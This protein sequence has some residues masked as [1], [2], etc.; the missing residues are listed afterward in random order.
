M[1]RFSMF[2]YKFLGALIFAVLIP[3]SKITAQGNCLLFEANSGERKACEL[4]YKASK[5]RQGSKASQLLFD[6]AIKVGSKFAYA[7]YQKSVPFFKRGMFAEGK[8]LIDKAISLEP[9]NYLFYRA[10]YYFYNRSYKLCR[11][12]LEELYSNHGANYVTTPGGELEMRILLGISYGMEGKY[13]EGINWMLN[14]M[15]KYKALPHLKGFYDH[16]CLGRLY[17][18]N[19]QT[20]LAQAEFEKQLLINDQF[21]DTFYYLGLIKEKQKEIEKATTYYQMALDK[22]NGKNGGFSSSIFADYN[23]TKDMVEMKITEVQ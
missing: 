15:E 12:D 16:Y 8:M 18:E 22:M 19:N 17:Y 20:D 14:L 23:V 3:N 13:N 21:A 6:E 1:E 11:R 2:C 9:Q 5:F 7:Y 10:Y 4:C